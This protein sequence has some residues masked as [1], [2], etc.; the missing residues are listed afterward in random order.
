MTEA[1]EE[2]TTGGFEELADDEY[3]FEAAASFAQQRLWFLDQLEPGL[4]VYNINF[5]IELNGALDEGALQAALDFLVARHESLRTTFDRPDQEPVQVIADTGRIAIEI[6]DV[7]AMD[8]NG[9]EAKLHQLIHLPFDLSRGPLLHVYLLHRG[10]DEYTLLFVIH[11]IIADAWSLDIFY[12]ELVS[13]YAAALAGSTPELPALSIQ[14]ADYAEWQRDW[15][16][17]DQLQKQLDYWQAQLA[18]APALLELPLD[19]PRP[20]IQ[21]HNG[22]TVEKVLPRKLADE[23]KQLAQQSG[24]TLF[25]LY[26][27]AFNVL[28]G[29]Y[30]AANDVVVGTPIAGRKRTEL[31][32]LI[33]FFVNTLAMRTDL[34][35]DPDFRTLLGRVK[36]TTLGAYGHQELPFEKLVEE[37]QP[38]R[39]MSHAPIFQVLFVLHHAVGDA[40]PFANLQTRSVRVPADTA[41]FDL[42]LY[43]TELRDGLSILF[44]YNTDLFD[45]S[46]IERMLDHFETLLGG[47][48]ARPDAPL[49]QLPLMDNAERQHVLQDFNASALP[50]EQ[51]RVHELVERQVN[52]TPAA[53]ALL[54]DGVTLSYAELNA[55]ANRLARALQKHGAG[56]GQLVGISCER[57]HRDG[58]QRARRT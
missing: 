11:H 58:R 34:S 40:L 13:A 44:E 49:S 12:R 46:T 18:D 56:P 19:R 24:C 5:A 50:V 21:T 27:A 26:L 7:A 48:V 20:R 28:L 25:I 51:L 22:S 10:P 23:L 15:L 29:R 8:R 57:S 52:A 42:S 54:M 55:R 45:R 37:L 47:I 3:V 38:E 2:R 43:V 33:G 39:T 41:K 35:G 1:N 31:E 30:A 17:G 16:A 36:Q 53:V 32:G 14:C 6:I 4:A 9:V